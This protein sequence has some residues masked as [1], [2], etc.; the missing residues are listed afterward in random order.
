MRVGASVSVVRRGGLTKTPNFVN[1]VRRFRKTGMNNQRDQI[2]A[3]ASKQGVIRPRDLVAPGLN[4]LY[5]R[6][7]VTEGRMVRTGRGLYSLA[8]FDATEDHTLVEAVLVQSKGVICLLSALKFHRIGTQLPYQVWLS[9]PYGSRISRTKPVP[10]RIVVMRAPSYQ[11]GIEAHQLEGVEVPI[12]SIA[13]TITDC[14]KF[15]NKIGLDVALEAL[16]EVLREKRCTRE[17]I[18]KFAKVNRV[19]KVMRPYLEAMTA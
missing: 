8:D 4:P 19:E 1:I 2:I 12:Y 11:T 13:K 15:R 18:R 16:R 14:F 7:L 3:L 9:V 17:E 10:M 6:Q 5:L